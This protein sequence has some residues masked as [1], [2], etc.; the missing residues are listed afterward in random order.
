VTVD[1]GACPVCGERRA[2]EVFESERFD[3]LVVVCCECGTGRP[4]RV[5]DDSEIRSFYPDAYYGDPGVKFTG[6]VESVVRLVG[7]RH[8]RFLARGVPS[9]GRILDV[10]CGRGVLLTTLAEHGYETHGVEVSEAA[11]RGADPRANIRIASRLAEARYPDGFFDLVI[12]WHVLEHLRN[13]RETLDEIRRIVRPGGRL[14]VSVPNFSS[15][16]ARW[17][18]AAWFHLDQ[19]RHLFHFPVAALRRMLVVSGFTCQTEHH[20]SLRQN[21]FGWIQSALNRRPYLPRNGLYTL[22]HSRP[23][24]E[25]PPFDPK[26]RLRLMAAAVP[27]VP[28]AMALSVAEV[29]V[30]SGATVHVVA[31][32]T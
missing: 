15:M 21:P 23:E 29:V 6:A 10:G 14:V 31:H 9:G 20:F 4:G 30:R 16:Q 25:P 5:P 11:A 27:L 13:P 17:A 12:L 1:A 19:P 7:A 28:V 2:R 26:T 24:G 3:V 32:R 8:A 18:G 22:L